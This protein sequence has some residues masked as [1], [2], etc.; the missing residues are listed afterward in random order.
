[1]KTKTFS[2]FHYSRANVSFRR[3]G[4]FAR[5]A[6][7]FTGKI[8]EEYVSNFRVT[9]QAIVGPDIESALTKARES[10]IY[11]DAATDAISELKDGDGWNRGL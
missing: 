5:L 10:V 4:F 2:T 3:L 11:S 8:K 6:V 7:L 1:M 9:Q